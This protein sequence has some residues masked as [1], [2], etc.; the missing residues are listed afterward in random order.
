MKKVKK[1]EE[2]EVSES[3]GELLDNGDRVKDKHDKT[4]D[5]TIKKIKPRIKMTHKSRKST[6]LS[7]SSESS[8]GSQYHEL[9][10]DQTTSLF[11]AIKAQIE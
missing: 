10:N 6:E 8:L 9:E 4:P 7:E 11:L 1:H 2:V 3:E 5:K